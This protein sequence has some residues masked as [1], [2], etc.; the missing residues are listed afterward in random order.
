MAVPRPSLG[1]R[2]LAAASRTKAA[3]RE[4]RNGLMAAVLQL[5]I[6]D[7]HQ[8]PQPSTT[9]G[10]E[11]HPLWA[12]LWVFCDDDPR[13]VDPFTFYNLCGALGYDPA[14]HARRIWDGIPEARRYALRQKFA[15]AVREGGLRVETERMREW[16]LA[17]LFKTRPPVPYKAHPLR[18]MV[19]RCRAARQEAVACQ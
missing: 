19:D 13:D 3:A 6:H 7:L 10:P 18:E 9:G 11:P 12:F 14:A 1:V 5:A 4:R 2:L 17:E 8:D 16:A 15:E